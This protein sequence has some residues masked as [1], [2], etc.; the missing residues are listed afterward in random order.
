MASIHRTII[1]AIPRPISMIDEAERMACFAQSARTVNGK[2]AEYRQVEDEDDYECDHR[3]SVTDDS[4]D[5]EFGTHRVT[6]Y[7]ECNNCGETKALDDE[8]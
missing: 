5:H 4:F 1:A 6:P 3:W 7:L 8:Y 2:R